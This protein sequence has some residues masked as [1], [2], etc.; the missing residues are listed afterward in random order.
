MPGALVAAVVFGVIAG[1]ILFARR[2]VP[3]VSETKVTPRRVVGWSGIAVGVVALLLLV[4]ASYNPVGTKEEGVVTSFN[5]PVGQH[6][7]GLANAWTLPWQE[8][9]QMDAAIQTDSYTGENDCLQ[10][11]IGAL[12]TGCAHVSIQWRIK[13]EAVDGLYQDFR[14][15]DHVRDALVTRRL[16]GAVNQVLAGYNPLEQ[17]ATTGSAAPKTTLVDLAG[18]IKDEMSGEVGDRI[19]ILN[20]QLPVI[21][22]DSAT[23]DRIN[24]LQQQYA[25][26]LIAEQQKITNE[27]QAAAN[28]ALSKGGHLTTPVLVQQC[29]SMVAAIYKDGGSVPAGWSCWPGGSSSI[30]IPAASSGSAAK[31]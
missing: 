30:V 9:H 7:P 11:R 8:V 22:F 15:F 10:A 23:Q 14:S 29:L 6:G 21:T 5:K 26:T 4:S 17:I 13:P 16:Q 12:Q 27:K 25:Q 31:P 20:V 28:A 24:Q 2:F 3:D 1:L 18:K 19:E